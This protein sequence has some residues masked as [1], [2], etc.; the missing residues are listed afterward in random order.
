[1]VVN[2]D[3]IQADCLKEIGNNKHCGVELGTGT[4]KTLLGLKHM[5]KQYHDSIMF[6]VVAPTLAIH[7]EWKEQAIKHGYSELLSHIKFV[8]YISLY[9]EQT[10]YDYVYLDECHNLKNKHAEWLR[11]HK[12]SILGMTGT[13]PKKRTS[14]SFKVCQ[15]FCTL[16]HSYNIDEGIADKVLNDYKIYVHML[17][18]NSNV[19]FNSSTNKTICETQNYGMWTNLI[20]KAAPSK[21]K[22]MRIMR[23]KAIQSYET[24]VN[25]AVKLLNNQVDKTLV[26]ADY[27][28]QADMICE[29]VYHSKDK[30]SDDNLKMFKSGAINKLSSVQQMAEG[31]NIPEL[32]TGIILHSYSDEKK[33]K[34]KIGRFL[35][36]NPT[37]KC[38]I[39][40]LCYRNTIDEKWCKNALKDFDNKKI[41]KYNGNL[42]PT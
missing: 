4:G 20:N 41:Y 6:L 38:T 34:Q 13:Y 22:L 33:L 7:R 31:V 11:L 37:E 15:E 12:G 30:K 32:K 39:H 35:R 8:T 17:D 10:D 27:T 21:I 29:Y 26:F 1:M 28:K 18:L 9:K 2:K 5:S 40:L 42:N 3:T 16:V 36:L 25:Y 19:Y 14:E 24:K 23:M